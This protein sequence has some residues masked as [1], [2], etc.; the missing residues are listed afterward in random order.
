MSGIFSTF[1]V[2][3][4]ALT[5]QRLRMDVIANNV[6]N[7]ETTNTQNGGPYQRQQVVFS[8]EEPEI[9]RANVAAP[10]KPSNEIGGGVRVKEI[11]SDDSPGHQVYDPD[12]PDADEEGFVTYPNVDLATEMTNMLSATRSYEANITVFNALKT[13]ALKALDIGRG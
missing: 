7:I 3:A 5:A 1:H 8:V 6:A 12:H 13:M 9:N 10:F 2:T 11:L 4:S